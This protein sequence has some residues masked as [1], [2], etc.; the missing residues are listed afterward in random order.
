[1]KYLG[2]VGNREMTFSMKGAKWER[3]KREKAR[4]HKEERRKL[5]RPTEHLSKMKMK[6]SK[7]NR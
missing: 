6:P 5:H 7:Q 4:L 3:E 1:M 2:S